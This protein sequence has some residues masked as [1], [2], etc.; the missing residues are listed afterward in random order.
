MHRPKKFEILAGPGNSYSKP[1]NWLEKLFG[2]DFEIVYKS[3]QQNKVA[4]ASSRVEEDKLLAAISR[5]F[6]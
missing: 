5:P 4:D 6:W 1:A 2:Y 3:G